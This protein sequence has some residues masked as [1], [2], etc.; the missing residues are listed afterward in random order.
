VGYAFAC[1]TLSFVVLQ[2]LFRTLRTRMR[3]T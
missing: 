3:D 2:K 1:A